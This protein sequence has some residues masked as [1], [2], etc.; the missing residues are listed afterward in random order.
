M[1]NSNRRTQT[2]AEIVIDAIA[3]DAIANDAIADADAIDAI[4]ID[5]IDIHAIHLARSRQMD[6]SETAGSRVGRGARGG[7]SPLPYTG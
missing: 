5:A 7:G 2:V 3:I 4:D 1:G 6:Q